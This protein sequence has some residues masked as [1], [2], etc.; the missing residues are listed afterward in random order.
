[1]RSCCCCT[2]SDAPIHWLVIRFGISNVMHIKELTCKLQSKWFN[3]VK[4]QENKFNQLNFP[5]EKTKLQNVHTK[6]AYYTMNR[7]KMDACWFTA[8]HCK[9]T[10]K[11]N[12]FV[13]SQMKLRLP[14]YYIATHSKVIKRNSSL[15][16]STFFAM[17][18]KHCPIYWCD[19]HVSPHQKS[20]G[21]SHRRHF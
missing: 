7:M 15:H 6:S 9:Y 11:F 5:E 1:M 17:K 14:F 19:S 8:L 3:T 21:Y 13:S 4:Y 20:V 10:Y 12:G 16:K 18:C 2:R